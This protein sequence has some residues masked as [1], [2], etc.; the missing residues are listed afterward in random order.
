[1]TVNCKC[2]SN[3]DILQIM[4]INIVNAIRLQINANEKQLIISWYQYPLKNVS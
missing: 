4:P 1:M 3:M 2:N